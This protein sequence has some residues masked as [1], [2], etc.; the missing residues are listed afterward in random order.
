MWGFS[1]LCFGGGSAG[2][3]GGLLVAGGVDGQL[4]EEF[5][6]GGV[7]DADL[8][9]VAEEQDGGS[10]VGSS[11]PD[12]VEASVDAQGEFAVAV[13]VVAAEPVVALGGAVG[14]RAGFGPGLVGG[15]GA[16]RAGRDRWG[17]WEL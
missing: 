9:V 7:D 12:V 14:V 11:D 8:K 5:A 17:R 15:G 1:C 3:A 4:A 6:G 16:L 13:D 10:G 2:S